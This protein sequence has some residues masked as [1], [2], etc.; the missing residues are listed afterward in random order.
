MATPHIGAQLI[1]FGRQYN[2]EED[3]DTILDQLAAGGYA[4]IEGSIPDPV[5]L[6]RKLITRGMVLAGLHTVPR[7]LL[8]KLPEQIDFMKKA[9]TYDICNSGCLDWKHTTLAEVESSIKILNEAGKKLREAGIRL[10]YHNHDFEFLVQFNGKRIID[11]MLEQ[12]DPKAV[13]LCVDVAW[14]RR[15]NDDPA[16]FLKKH[17]SRIG[18]LHFKDFEADAEGKWIRWCEVGGG[19]VDYRAIMTALPLLKD[20][21]Y[22]MVE[23]DLPLGNAMLNMANSRAY[24]KSLGL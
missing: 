15:G 1:I 3:F 2:L 5:A 17:A 21:Q 9:R 13:D 4:A 10:H 6:R 22:A 7:V 18:Y 20:V 14:V 23:Q 11:I 12:F 8:E 24:L 19:A 16:A